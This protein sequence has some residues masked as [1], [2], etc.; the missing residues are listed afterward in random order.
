[1]IHIE[2]PENNVKEV[3]E[4]CISNFRDESLKN[5]LQSILPFIQSESSDYDVKASS[6]SLFSLTSST[7]I[8]GIVTVDEMQKVYDRK[9][10][11][12]GQ[13]GR[14]HYEKIKLS[15][16]H[17]ICPLCDHR[18]VT[19]LDHVL[20]K[21]KYPTFAVT[22]FNLVPAC[23]DCNKIKDANLTFAPK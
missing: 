23:G 20:P 1:M 2:K 16:K 3:F 4:D 13:P 21:S 19:T 18:T 7:D 8:N 11:K 17:N 5:R 10:V 9:L 6:S 12:K 22:P 14:K 15:A